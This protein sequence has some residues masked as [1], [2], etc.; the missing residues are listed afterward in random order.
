M[1]RGLRWQLL[2]LVA[3]VV[4]FLV[5]LL[6]RTPSTPSLPEPSPEITPSETVAPASPT[7]RVAF[8]PQPVALPAEQPAIP[9][10]REAL[11]GEVQRLNPL[12]AGL[13]S[14]DAAITS[15][16]FEG[17]TRINAYGEVE[18]LLAREMPIVSFDGLEYVVLLREDVLWHDGTP[19]T[20]DDVV[21]TASLLSSA[22]FPGSAELAALWRTVETQKIDPYTVRFRLA[23]PLASFP[24][25]L[26]VG[27][28]P[29]HALQGTTATQLPS[30]LFNLSPI[31]TGPYQ[32]EALRGEADNI[33]LVDLR[34]APNYQTRPEAAEGYAFDR[35]RFKLYDDL[36]SVQQALRQDESDA[37]AARTPAE[38]AML[39]NMNDIVP[40]TAY[41]PR[42]GMLVFNWA[43]EDT[44]YFQEQ[45][46]REALAASLNRGSVVERHLTNMAVRADSPLLPLSWAYREGLPWPENDLAAAREHLR[47]AGF[48]AEDQSGPLF[49][50]T[51]LTIDQPAMQGIAQEVAAQWSQLNIAV[52]VE[53]VDTAIFRERLDSGAFDAALVEFSKSGIAD[54]DVYTFWHEGQYPDGQNYGGASDRDISEVLERGRRDVNGINRAVHY[55][56]FQQAFAERVI[57]IPLYYPLFTYG[58]SERVAGVQLGYISAPSDRFQ[59]IEQWTLTADPAA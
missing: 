14:V 1:L 15:L 59:T 28:L 4:L 6:T 45:R 47:T 22:D 31:G 13:N 35:V 11:V 17:L 56:R 34:L 20:A 29:Y 33:S 49:E 37:F 10:Y 16:I 5:A 46:V 26:K 58:V 30:H 43:S 53:S 7:P 39:L 44:P 12:L 41:A 23:Q 54:P 24:E 52:T 38:R 18:P 36:N 2:S 21:Y 50:F 32:L 9:T 55:E 8:T 27:M 48:A 19:F 25:A 57:A 40:Y 51:I 3:A 42:V